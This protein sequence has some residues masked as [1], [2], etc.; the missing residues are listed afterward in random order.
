MPTESLLLDVI[1]TARHK[2][3]KERGIL[4]ASRITQEDYLVGSREKAKN[5]ADKVNNRVKVT[6]NGEK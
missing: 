1:V 2:P 5:F 4:F 6:E 3:V